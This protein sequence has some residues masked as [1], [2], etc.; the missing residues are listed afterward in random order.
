MSDLAILKKIEG[1]E[2]IPETQLQWLLDTGVEHR[3]EQGEYLFKEGDPVDEMIVI[4]EGE[5]VFKV[6]Q[7]GQF[8]MTG[9][10]EAPA[11]TGLLPYSRA[12]TARA[13][14]QAMTPCRFLMINRKFMREMIVDCEDV[15]RALVH[16]MSNRVRRFTQLQRQNDKMLALGKLSAGLAHELNNPSAAIVR[17]AQMLSRHLKF[18]P[19]NFKNVI[20]I[21][22]T[23]EIVDQINDVLFS[24]VEEGVQHLTMLEKSSQEDDLLDW[25]EDNEIDNAEEITEN[26]VDF[27]FQE[28]ELDDMKDVLRPEDLGPV[29]NWLNQVLTTERLVSEIEEASRRI[30]DLVSSVKSYTHMDQAPEKKPTDIHAGIDNTITMLNHKL[31]KANI[32]V[33]K[34]YDA[35]IPEAR[36]LI[37]EMNQVWTN[38]IDNAIDAME[39]SDTKTLTISTRKNG[40]FINVDVEDSGSG[41]PE[42]VISRIFDPFFTTKQIGK[43]TGIG[44]EVVH[45]IITQQHHGSVDVASQPGK[46]VFTICFPLEEA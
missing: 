28:D 21:R 1:F 9:R 45:Q 44:L 29:V 36:I 13:F 2:H 8:R 5:Y 35:S 41:I 4:L 3:S 6:S 16:M 30:N 20:K 38:L 31:K 42:E 12:T 25:L 39:K 40:D 24:K 14:A 27:G 18:L 46:T 26:L 22:T 43:G 37:S 7:N 32:E 23:G 10:F 11:V 17:S 34:K 15:T 19:E 33:V